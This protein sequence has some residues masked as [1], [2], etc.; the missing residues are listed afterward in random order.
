MLPTHN[1]YGALQLSLALS[2]GD[3]EWIGFP[4]RAEGPVLYLALDMP[5]SLWKDRFLKLQSAGVDIQPC[6]SCAEGPGSERP[7]WGL[8]FADKEMAPYPFDI[9]SPETGGAY[10]QHE[11]NRI[12]PIMVVIDTLRET[13]DANENDSGQMKIVL[14]TLQHICQPAAIVLITHAKK[15]SAFMDDDP[16]NDIRGSGQISARL[17]TILKCTQKRLFVKGRAVEDLKLMLGR[18]PTLFWKRA[19]GPS[20][21]SDET[22]STLLADASKSDRE[23]AI[24]L[25]K[26]SG[27]STEAARSLI[28][29]YRKRLATQAAHRRENE[30]PGGNGEGTEGNRATT[31]LEDTPG[32]IPLVPHTDHTTPL[33]DHCNETQ[34]T[35]TDA[36][37]ES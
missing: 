17:D 10:L 34:S 23:L 20:Q 35:E 13:T 21:V 3:Q 26:Q 28:R 11:V 29:Y 32:S 2:Q 14:N 1:S 15:P 12:K 5:A 6:P 27:R 36:L 30:M 9:L 19:E 4:V 8:H 25:G 16:V 18:E 31:P 22:L 24:T 37:L 7:H 33:G